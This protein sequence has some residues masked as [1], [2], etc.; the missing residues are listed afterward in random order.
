MMDALW[1][2]STAAA[3]ELGT[4]ATDEVRLAINKCVRDDQAPR[5]MFDPFDADRSMRHHMLVWEKLLTYVL[6][7]RIREDPC[8]AKAS[9]M[10]LRDV[11]FVFESLLQRRF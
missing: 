9:R 1:E 3:V 5:G 2:L 8:P 11:R 7:L 6:R 10:H 4:E